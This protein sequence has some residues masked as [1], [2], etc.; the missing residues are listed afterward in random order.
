MR[1]NKGIAKLLVE[2]DPKSKEFLCEDGTILVEIRRSLYGLPEAAQLWYNY[3][4]GALK[5][6]GYIECPHDPC[7]FM[8]KK[9]SG[10]VSIISIYV[11]YCL[12]IYSDKRIKAELYTALRNANLHDLKIES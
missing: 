12:H 5:G 3:M 2:A 4:S 8:R 1:I 9:K 11:D 6:G 10:E 7:I